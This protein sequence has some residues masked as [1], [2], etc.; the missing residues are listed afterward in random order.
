VACDSRRLT[1]F[2]GGVATRQAMCLPLA[3][4]WSGHT[5]QL[6]LEFG[7]GECGPR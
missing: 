3:V 1:H 2:A 6:R 5:E 7:Q 4:S